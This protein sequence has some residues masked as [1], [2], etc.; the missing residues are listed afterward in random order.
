MIGESKNIF[1]VIRKWKKIYLSTR[2]STGIGL[3][4]GSQFFYLAS[5]WATQKSVDAYCINKYMEAAW[6][7][8]FVRRLYYIPLYVYQIFNV[9]GIQNYSVVL[10]LL[11]QRKVNLMRSPIQIFSPFQKE[12][13]LVFRRTKN[14][15]L[16]HAWNTV[17][18]CQ[19]NHQRVNKICI[20]FWLFLAR[21]ISSR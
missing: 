2:A 18:E 12:V 20:C 14:C 17:R 1:L 15:R 5:F 16:D 3:K 19:V 10:K 6:H 8:V 21:N 7:T 4:F 13:W 9:G 11:R